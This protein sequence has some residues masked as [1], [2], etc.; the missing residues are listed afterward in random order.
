MKKSILF[1]IFVMVVAVTVAVVSCKKEWHETVNL[2]E[3]TETQTLMYQIKAFQTLRESVK[4]GIKA[5]GYMSV[6]EMRHNL[7]LTANY[8]HSEHMT[9][10]ENTILDT[11]YLAMPPVDEDGNVKVS[12]VLATYETFEAELQQHMER[13]DDGSSLPSYFGIVMPGKDEKAE[14][15]IAVVFLR[16]EEGKEAKGDRNTLDGDGPFLEDLDT[17]Y[18]GG[19]LGKCKWDPYNATSD[20]SEQ[21]SYKFG[22]VIPE[23]HQGQNY[24]VYDV[25][26]MNYR[27]C[28]PDVFVGFSNYYV[29]PNMED[30]ADTWLYCHVSSV[31]VDPC[32]YWD[33]LNCYWRSIKRNIV[34]PDAPLHYATIH[35]GNIL[36]PYHCC[37]IG[38]Y[39][40]YHEFERFGQYYQ[41]HVAHVTYCNI[42]WEESPLPPVD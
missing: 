9:Y 28:N 12:D 19:D 20:A 35:H 33:E 14:D 23:E 6:E 39:R 11:L 26:H 15:C 38:W 22:F 1:S 36:V 18:W 24:Y 21:L 40:F 27:P 32:L 7:D 30:C 5:E 37:L 3:K 10:C 17:W 4:S 31:P 42:H 13:V 16:G 8:E 41:I 34:D 2:S 25:V 29:D